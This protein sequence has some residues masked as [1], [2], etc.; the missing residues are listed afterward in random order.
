MPAN[1]CYAYFALLAATTLPISALFAFT[2]AIAPKKKYTA[3]ST[4]HFL[5][6]RGK[7]LLKNLG[8]KAARKQLVAAP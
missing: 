5:K 2:I 1:Y 6:T 3:K 8:A 7:I 4:K